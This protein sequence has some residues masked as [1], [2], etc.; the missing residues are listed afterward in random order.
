MAED[1]AE[2]TDHPIARALGGIAGATVGAAEG[3]T[4]LVKH[5]VPPP[6]DDQPIRAEE[7][8]YEYSDGHMRYVFITGLSLLAGIWI[9]SALIYVYFAYLASHRA[10]S[11]NPPLPAN[12]HG[13]VF[14]PSPQLQHSP[15]LDLQAMLRAQNA[16]QTSY[17]WLNRGKGTVTIPIDRAMRIV[18]QS[19]IPP[20]KTSPNV[21][22]SDPQQG[23]L[24]TG[25]EGSEGKVE[26][27]PK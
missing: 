7:T 10:G 6:P 15:P 27:E 13:E 11:S 9:I 23:T 2:H 3:V 20:Q 12:L 5:G 19:G 4:N 17:H 22:L 1:R 24:L 16:E 8:Y 18:A 26:P 14:P 25:F 21:T